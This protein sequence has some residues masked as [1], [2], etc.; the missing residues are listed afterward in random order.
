MSK[1]Y[2]L[3]SIPG[4]GKTTTAIALAKYFR[5]QGMKVANLQAIKGRH[6]AGL[7]MKNDCYHYSIPLE[8]A[9][10]RESLA[11]WLP[12]D[13][14]IHI[15]EVGFP[16]SPLGAAYIDRF[17]RVN[18]IISAEHMDDWPEFIKGNMLKWYTCS[19][20]LKLWDLFHSRTVQPV[21]TKTEG[22]I[23]NPCV[24][25]NQVIHHVDSLVYD[26]IE[27]LMVLPRSEKKAIAVGTFPAEFWDIY[28]D[29][30]WHQYNYSAFTE[31]VKG[32]SY[33]LAIVG[34]CADQSVKL[35][36]GGFD[37]PVICYQ[38]SALSDRVEMD[39]HFGG[40]ISLNPVQMLETIKAQPV[41]TSLAPANGSYGRFS[42]RFWV[43]QRY[44]GADILEKEG[45]VLFCN[46][47]VLPQYLMREGL[48]EV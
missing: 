43:F 48:L 27:P 28:P 21:I 45:N 36:V 25:T 37:L 20:I 14:D 29:L 16:Y 39:T 15:I 30:K 12:K 26:E 10:S 13:F 6:D 32:G 24:D 31:A 47:W 8:A 38:P 4:Q 1:V 42:N 40:R 5:N 41:G 22:D 44:S 7:Y 33:D 46:G 17:D 2:V 18:E 35:D 3:G 19:K 11:Q 9:K 23:G 34:G